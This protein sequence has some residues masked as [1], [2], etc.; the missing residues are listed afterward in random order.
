ME[1]LTK[2]VVYTWSNGSIGTRRYESKID[3]VVMNENWKELWTMMVCNL[4]QGGSS[5]H[6]NLEV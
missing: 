5:D 4:Y 3:R 1:M 2:G 6:A